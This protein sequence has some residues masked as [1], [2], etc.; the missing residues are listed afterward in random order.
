M[1]C[2]VCKTRS[3][4]IDSRE[5]NLHLVIHRTYECPECFTRFKSS[6]K[7]LFESIPSYIRNKFLEEGK[8]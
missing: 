6:E 4:V 5:P 8:R 3:R 1:K 7:V 2:P